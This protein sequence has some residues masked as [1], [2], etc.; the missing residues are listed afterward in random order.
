MEVP[1][2]LLSVAVDSVRVL[3]VLPAR[4]CTP[5]IYIRTLQVQG[6]EEVYDL[7]SS[8]PRLDRQTGSAAD[9]QCSGG[10]FTDNVVLFNEER[11]KW[12]SR[13]VGCLK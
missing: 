11:A 2:E 3:C 6:F 1:C 12:E 13:C 7:L 5:H 8:V 4:T 9:M 10:Q